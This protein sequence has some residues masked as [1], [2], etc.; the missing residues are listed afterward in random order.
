MNSSLRGFF[1]VQPNH[2]KFV[3]ELEHLSIN[4][5]HFLRG[6]YTALSFLDLVAA[7]VG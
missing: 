7:A 1:L 6:F 5:F 2:R 3:K 4:G